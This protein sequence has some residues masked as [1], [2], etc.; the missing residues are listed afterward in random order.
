MYQMLLEP[1]AV[2]DPSADSR[3]EMEGSGVFTARASHR[4]GNC[5]LECTKGLVSY[6]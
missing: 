5:K 6:F 2:D 3:V 4:N 1:E